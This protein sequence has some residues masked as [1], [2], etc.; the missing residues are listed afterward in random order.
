MIFCLPSLYYTTTRL[1]GSTKKIKKLTKI[2]DVFISMYYD[3]ARLNIKGVK[4][5]R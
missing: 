3:E 2:V 1:E 4:Y 5:E